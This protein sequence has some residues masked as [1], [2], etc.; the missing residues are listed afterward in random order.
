M[1]TA[2]APGY[3]PLSAST[4]PGMLQ[5]SSQFDSGAIEMIAADGPQDIRL[6]LRADR[7]ADFRQWF[8]FRLPDPD[9]GWSGAR[10][11]RLGAAML[12]PILG[13]FGAG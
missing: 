3:H 13:H 5:I 6:N 11:R 1:R 8:H 12:N 4:I 10:S 2:Q 7:A 9:A